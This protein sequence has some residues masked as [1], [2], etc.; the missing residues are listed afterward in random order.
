[1][2]YFLW[3]FYG[4]FYYSLE[5]RK[6]KLPAEAL[7][8]RKPQ[9]TQGKVINFNAGLLFLNNH[10]NHILDGVQRNRVLNSASLGI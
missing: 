10:K 6:L 5:H 4:I 3:A 9:I 2:L 8:R 1:M 7:R